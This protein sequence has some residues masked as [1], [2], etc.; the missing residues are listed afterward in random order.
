M[1]ASEAQVQRH[2]LE[3]EKQLKQVM[4]QRREHRRLSEQ[5]YMCLDEQA[6]RMSE[7]M[8]DSR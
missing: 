7:K 2:A 6:S 5:E 3:Y 1:A 8:A 4:T